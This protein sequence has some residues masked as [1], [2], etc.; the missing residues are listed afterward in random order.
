MFP[1]SWTCVKPLI[2]KNHTRLLS[3]LDIYG[4][5]LFA[6]DWFKSYLSNRLECVKLSSIHSHFSPMN[7]GVPQRSILGLLL[8]LIYVND[9]SKTSSFL[10]IY[11]FADDTNCLYTRDDCEKLK[12]KNELNKMFEW[13]K[14]NE[15]SLIILKTQF[16]QTL[17]KKISL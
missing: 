12:L 11:L 10:N 6:L 13:I 2:L 7:Y 14:K 9:L 17:G 3:K 5:R 1:F 4:V 15:R 8:F 16:L